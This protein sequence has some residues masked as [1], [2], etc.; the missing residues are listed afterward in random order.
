MSQRFHA[1]SPSSQADILLVI[2]TLLAGAGWIFSKE[3]LQG[4]EPIFFVSIRFTLAG[5]L[6]VLLGQG[7]LRRLTGLE[8]KQACLV[9]S[10]FS[11][12]MILWILG[13]HYAHHV[14]I[15]AFLTSLGVVLVPF[16][17]LL[18][19]DRP[20]KSLWLSLPV[21]IAGLACLSLD[22]Q[23]TFGWGEVFFLLAALLFAFFF[24]LN[25]RYSAKIATL[26]LTAIQLLITG[27]V[28]FVV[29]LLLEEQQWSQPASI[30]GWLLASAFIATSLRFYVQT[31]AQ[32]MA[33]SSHTAIIMTLEPVW[34]ALFAAFW[35]NEQMTLLQFS[36]CMLI[37]MAML[38]NRWRV[39]VQLMK[40]S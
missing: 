18:F 11:V 21:V 9:G 6:L 3:A 25:S 2:T 37:F 16:V 33:P 22:S 1:L 36:G 27:A 7:V 30:W 5:L 13:L 12:A 4:L 15:G 38:I 17:G 28:A 34:T 20:D 39:I 32:G 23:F 35:L 8:F 10:V 40:R 26:P 31:K 29:S 19:G 24:V 14:G